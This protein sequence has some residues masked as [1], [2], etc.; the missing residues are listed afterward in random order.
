[1]R[2]PT[3]LASPICVWK[4]NQHSYQ[5]QGR[6]SRRPHVWEAARVQVSTAVPATTRASTPTLVPVPVP[7]PVPAAVHVARS[8]T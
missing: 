4:Q 3:Y 6:C 7:V 1:M 2:V 8:R 5:Y